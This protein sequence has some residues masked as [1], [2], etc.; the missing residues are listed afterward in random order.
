[1]ARVDKLRQRIGF[2]M[3]NPGDTEQDREESAVLLR[4]LRAK[5][6]EAEMERAAL[7]AAR[8][9]PKVVPTKQE[10]PAKWQSRESPQGASNAEYPA[11]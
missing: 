9:R 1:V 11:A 5:R 2:V 4:R 3:S 7:E 10:S 8:D 6:A